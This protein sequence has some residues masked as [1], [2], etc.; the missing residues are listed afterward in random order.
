VPMSHAPGETRPPAE[1]WRHRPSTFVV[2]AEDRI[3]APEQQRRWAARTTD[4]VEW[5]SDH[6]PMLSHPDELADLLAA[7]AAR[8]G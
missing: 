6:S 4:A 2:C 3:L 7:L 5:D 8:T 1:A